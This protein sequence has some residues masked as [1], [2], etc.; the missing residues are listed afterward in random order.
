MLD[1]VPAAAPVRHF[2][3]RYRVNLPDSRTL[4]SDYLRML[5]VV[6]QPPADP[7]LFIFV[8]EIVQNRLVPCV[9]RS[10]AWRRFHYDRF[11]Y[12]LTGGFGEIYVPIHFVIVQEITVRGF[13]GRAVFHLD[14][15]GEKSC[16]HYGSALQIIWRVAG[17]SFEHV[18]VNWDVG[19][20]IGYVGAVL[21]LVELNHVCVCGIARGITNLM[22][23][24]DKRLRNRR[25][26]GSL[27]LREQ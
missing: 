19:I 22:P 11:R 5:E 25:H 12:G 23:A 15:M 21:P 10:G 18:P 9:Q 8:H 17:Q 4:C 20:R 27:Q 16:D 1:V 24:D 26:S 13:A 14:P 6:H 2:N 7:D 3:P